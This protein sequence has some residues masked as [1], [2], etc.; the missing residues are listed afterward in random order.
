[1][2]EISER[3]KKIPPYL[4]V[5]IDRKKKE[6]ILKGEDVIDFGVG[7]PDMPT[8]ENIIEAMKKAVENPQFHRYPFGKGTKEFRKAISSFYK[9]NYDVDIDYENEICVLIGSKE[10]IAHFP[11]CFI[12]PGD[13]SLVPEPGY[14]V[15]NIGTLIA[16]GETYFLPLKE[17]NNFLP[18]LGKIPNE[19]VRKAK[20]LYLNY[21][22]NP[23]GTFAP[24]EFLK[25]VVQFCIKNK[26][27]LVYDAAYSEIYFEKRPINIFSIEGAKKVTIE[28]NSL[29]KTYNM[30]GWR[31]GWACGNS[32]LISA[33][34]KIKENIDSG[35]FEAIQFAG[36]E[37]LTGPQTSVIKIR[38]I[39][40]KR[41]DIFAE[42]LKELG[43]DFNLPLG[44]FYFWIK[45][46]GSSVKFVDFLLENG[47]IV[48]TP[49]IGFGP[50]GEGFV[51]FSLTINEEKIIEA[52][53]RIKRIWVR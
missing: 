15:Y 20:I 51:R 17:E 46:N 28:F 12:N 14:P 48:A 4:F 37:A 22:N 2:F 38:E 34:A 31:V 33:L 49:G 26:I 41:R 9:K 40:K 24:Y 18:D 5:E 16:G 44:T 50:S 35:T 29:S 25:E 43:I 23:T 32:S 39:Y 11:L 27:I 47:K 3:L 10:G 7:D 13:I 30:T 6:M 8:P 42:G 36:I 19:I 52:I 1:M 45:I 21:P 53:K